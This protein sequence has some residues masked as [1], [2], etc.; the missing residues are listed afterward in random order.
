MAGI[1]IAGIYGRDSKAEK[2]NLGLRIDCT[3]FG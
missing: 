2:N 1:G 3:G